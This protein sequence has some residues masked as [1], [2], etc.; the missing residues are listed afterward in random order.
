[1]S[2]L[3]DNGNGL[4]LGLWLGFRVKIPALTVPVTAGFDRELLST[5]STLC[6][7]LLEGVQQEASKLVYDVKN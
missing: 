7:K 6:I 3:T 5:L 4:G 2:H 1:L